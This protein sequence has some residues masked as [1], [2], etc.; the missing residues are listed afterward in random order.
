V[1]GNDRPTRASARPPA[2]GLRAI[3]CVAWLFACGDPNAQSPVKPE[4]IAIPEAPA[5]VSDD[6]YAE[7][8]NLAKQRIA[9]LDYNNPMAIK[10]AVNQLTPDLREISENAEDKHLRA[11][12][13]LLVGSLYE[14]ADDS[15]SAIAFYRQAHGLLPEEIEAVRVLAL[16]LGAD[17]Q[18]AEAAQLQEKVV[19][20]DMDDLASWLLLG[21]LHLKAGNSEEAKKAYIRYEIR[22]KGLIDGLTLQKDGVFVT[23]VDDRL[24]CAQALLPASDNGTA[25]ALLYA[26]KY[27]PN[28]KVRSGIINTMG[29]QRLAGYKKAIEE[30]L[31]IEDDPVVQEEARWA[32]DEIARDP[33]D[34]RPGAPPELLDPENATPAEGD[35]P[36]PDDAP[37][38]EGKAPPD[39]A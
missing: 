25:I 22:R 28:A 38:V 32:L 17:G 3:A 19:A 31:A 24:G 12:A 16:V 14:L 9:D 4:S 2:R 21:E 29:V 10:G 7:R 18:Y 5:K 15:R 35:A 39:P 33:L 23:S 1:F 37:A 11:N 30:R 27:E 36:A 20:D 13:S 34:T 6:A 8:Y 26:L